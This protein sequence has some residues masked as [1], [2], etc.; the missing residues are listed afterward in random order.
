MTNRDYSYILCQNVVTQL[1]RKHLIIVL[2]WLL[3]IH[4]LHL[5]ICH[6]LSVIYPHFFILVVSSVLL[7]NQD[8]SGLW[9]CFFESW[10]KQSNKTK[11][12]RWECRLVDIWPITGFYWPGQCSPSLEWSPPWWGWFRTC[13]P[14]CLLLTWC[15]AGTSHLSC[16]WPAQY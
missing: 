5:L 15:T 9:Y 2:R 13:A 14:L 10:N 16:D 4:M 12:M 11:L 7:G 1:E 3:S 8:T 6:S